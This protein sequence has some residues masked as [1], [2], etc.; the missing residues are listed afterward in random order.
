M[1]S[2]LIKCDILGLKAEPFHTFGEKTTRIVTVVNI[3]NLVTCVKSRSGIMMGWMETFG[4][5]AVEAIGWYI[6]ARE[7]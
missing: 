6:V 4:V 7:R 2:H 1:P 3:L 5:E